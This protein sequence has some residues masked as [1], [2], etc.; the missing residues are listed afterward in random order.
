[1]NKLTEK[2]KNGEKLI[3]TLCHLRSACELEALG[4]TGLDFVMLDLEHSPLDIGEA[5]NLFAS[6]TAVGIEAL[7][8]INEASRTPILKC[9]DAG[10]Q[11][12]I[13]PGIE[14]VEQVKKIIEWGKFYPLGNRGYCMTRD[15]GWG[16]AKN[17][18]SGLRGYMDES[19]ADTLL[20]PQCE[21]RGCLE[22]IEEIMSMD[23]VDGVLIGPYD[24]SMDMGIAGEFENPLFKA[25]VAR[26]L[27]ACKDNGK[28]AINFSG[29]KEG[30]SGVLLQ[31]FDGVLYGLDITVLMDTY[32]KTVCDI[33]QSIKKA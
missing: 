5:A 13:V 1:M 30:A 8:R 31:G 29:T 33:R 12:I 20:I 15:G 28:L 22:H 26:V 24:L 19:N 25:A 4:Y 10:A 17:Y 11:G 32:K 21:T 7:I 18:S 23:G 9:L 27:K 3:G 16:Y 14:S 6:C 2:F